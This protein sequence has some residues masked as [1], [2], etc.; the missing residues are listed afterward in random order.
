MKRWKA[1]TSTSSRSIQSIARAWRVRIDENRSVR[2]PLAEMG[3]HAVQLLLKRIK[4]EACESITLTPQL[5]VRA[6][7]SLRR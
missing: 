6:S 2:L 3:Q 5:Q 4:G 1:T 7:S